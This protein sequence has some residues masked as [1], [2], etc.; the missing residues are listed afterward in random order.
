MPATMTRATAATRTR[1]RGVTIALWVT[2]VLLAAF[3]VGAAAIP[4]LT[5]NEVAVEM[6]GVIGLGQWF[7]YF[8]GAVELAGAIGLLIPRLCGLAAIGLVLTMVGAVA[9][10]LTV[11]QGGLVTLT[12]ALLGAVCAVIARGQWPN[13]RR[14]AELVRR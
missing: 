11:L 3:F 4:K 8:V 5:G 7:R 1:P 12:P 9:T 2:Q 13:T 10:Q 14:L 6:F